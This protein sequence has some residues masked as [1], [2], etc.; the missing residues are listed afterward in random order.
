LRGKTRTVKGGV[1]QEG[2]GRR[3]LRPDSHSPKREKGKKQGGQANGLRT[4]SDCDLGRERKK[5]STSGWLLKA[6]GPNGGKWQKKNGPP[7]RTV[8][9]RKRRGR[10]QSHEKEVQK[11]KPYGR[12]TKKVKTKVWG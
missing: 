11:G 4:N 9:G 6:C 5:K 7:S 12:Q 3:T 8:R 10:R 1:R 2:G